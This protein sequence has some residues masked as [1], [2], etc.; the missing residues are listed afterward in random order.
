VLLAMAQWLVVLSAILLP[1][2]PVLVMFVLLLMT[3]ATLAYRRLVRMYA[4]AQA[5]LHETLSQPPE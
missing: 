3:I 5:A 4:N 2:W 1:P